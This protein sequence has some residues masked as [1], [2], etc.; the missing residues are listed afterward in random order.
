MSERL[1][2]AQTRRNSALRKGVCCAACCRR[3]NG[4]RARWSRLVVVL[5]TMRPC[6]KGSAERPDSAAK[7]LLHI[8]T[9]RRKIWPDFV[10]LAACER[11]ASVNIECVA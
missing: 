9:S 3:V 8:L 10:L 7:A 1:S 6:V 4:A 5:E 11:L 2:W